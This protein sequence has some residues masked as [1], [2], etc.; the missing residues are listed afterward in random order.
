MALSRDNEQDFGEDR[1]RITLREKLNKIIPTGASCKAERVLESRVATGRWRR[2]R[3]FVR[4]TTRRDRRTF[5]HHCPL[6]SAVDVVPIRSIGHDREKTRSSTLRFCGAAAYLCQQMRSQC[7]FNDGGVFRSKH[8]WFSSEAESRSKTRGAANT[9]SDELEVRI[10]PKPPAGASVRLRRR[11]AGEHWQ[12]A[13]IYRALPCPRLINVTIPSSRMPAL[14]HF[15]IRWIMRGSLIRCFRKR[16][17]HCWL[18]ES[19][20]ASTDY[21]YP[22]CSGS[23]NR[24]SEAPR[25]RGAH[26]TND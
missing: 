10:S 17:S 21:P 18:T 13:V 23:C 9:I 19:K 3:V 6:G 4:P 26:A 16:I 5:K 15:W 20:E 8:S 11:N 12:A 22:R 2:D 7:L 25:V 1:T 14:S 24:H